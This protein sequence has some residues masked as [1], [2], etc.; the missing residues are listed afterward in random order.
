MKTVL[1]AMIGVFLVLCQWFVFQ[2]IRK[3]LWPNSVRIGQNAAYIVL[4]AFGLLTVLAIRLE[5]GSEFFAPGTLMRQ[6]A[7]TILRS[8]L[9]WS[10]VLSIFFSFVKLLEHL[11]NLRKSRSVSAASQTDF[12]SR[13]NPLANNQTQILNETVSI[14][15]FNPREL[16]QANDSLTRRRFLKL[17]ATTSLT[18]A[19]GVGI[20]G[21]ANAYGAPVLE[22]HEITHDLLKGIRSPVTIIHVSDFHF[23]MFFGQRELRNLVDHLNSLEGD[24]LSITGD[25]FHSSRTL[26]DQA[27]P[28]LAKLKSRNLGNFAV[29]GNHDLYAGEM[30]SAQSLQSAGITLLRNE[31]TPL[32]V[33]NSTIYLGGIDDPLINWIKTHEVWGFDPFMEQIPGDPAFRLMLSHRPDVFPYAVDQKIEVVLAGHT[34]G[35]QVVIP[36]PTRHKGISVADIVSKYTYGWY[37]T[38][39]SRMYVNRG[40]GLSFLPWRLHCPPEIAVIR[41]KSP[42]SVI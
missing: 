5:F 10:L 18:I 32:K 27:I 22:R 4:F 8:Y 11:T 9:G 41:L 20:K 38:T 31:W 34:H 15:H 17:A 3:Y 13:Y 1:L 26:V 23:G 12:T 36:V 35:G 24:I 33:D 42:S 16:G 7:S 28:I 37:E 25:V 19:T 14:S 29:L 21:T 40:V 30:R 6:L 39:G 2:S